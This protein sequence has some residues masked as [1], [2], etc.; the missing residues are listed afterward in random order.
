MMPLSIPVFDTGPAIGDTVPP[1]VLHLTKM[2]EGK[3]G[4]IDSSDAWCHYVYRN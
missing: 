2:H 3:E 1:R 4:Q